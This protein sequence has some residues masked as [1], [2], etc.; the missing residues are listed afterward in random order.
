MAMDTTT[1]SCQSK[2][3]MLQDVRDVFAGTRA[4]QTAPILH[5]CPPTRPAVQRNERLKNRLSIRTSRLREF[6]SSECPEK[7]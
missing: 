5:C 3:V 4:S 1:L 7:T 6:D 2:C